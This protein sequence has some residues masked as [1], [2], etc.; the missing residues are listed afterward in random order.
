MAHCVGLDSPASPAPLP[1]PGTHSGPPQLGSHS[2][3]AVNPHSYNTWG[4]CLPPPIQESLLLVPE[5][6]Q[7]SKHSISSMQ[8]QRVHLCAYSCKI[9]RASTNLPQEKPTPLTMC[10]LVCLNVHLYMRALRFH[11]CPRISCQ[12][13]NVGMHQ[14]KQQSFT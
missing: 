8:T 1:L 3:H 4:T 7:T 9:L 11:C 6:C 12:G 14:M 5:H 2:H 10:T 13:E